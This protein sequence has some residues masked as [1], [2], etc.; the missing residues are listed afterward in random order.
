MAQSSG[1]QELEEEIRDVMDHL[2]VEKAQAVHRI[3]EIGISEWR[4]RTA[5]EL[6]R[7]GKVTFAG[8]AKIAKV[9]LWDLTDLLKDRKIEW[10]KISAEEVA[11]E[12]RTA[13]R[14]IGEASYLRRHPRS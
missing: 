9:D 2:K 8:G 3:L 13:K 4:K 7:D 11:K 5:L 6:L 10:V 14:D 12:V 1:F